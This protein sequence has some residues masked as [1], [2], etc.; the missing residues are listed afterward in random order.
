VPSTDAGDGLGSATGAGEAATGS[1]AMAV[2]LGS[3][4]GEL[5]PHDARNVRATRQ[6]TARSR[7]ALTVASTSAPSSVAIVN[8]VVAIIG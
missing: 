8:A 6:P 1:L 5:P 3:S 2:A 7:A 4:D